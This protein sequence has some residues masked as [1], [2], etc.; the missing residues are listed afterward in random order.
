MIKTCPV[1]G[2]LFDC[3]YTDMWAYNIDKKVFFCSW[4]CIQQHRQ[5]KENDKMGKITLEQ[6]KKAV[7]I[8]AKGGDPVTFLQKCGSEKPSVSWAN[9][10]R[11]LETSKPELYDMLTAQK[12]PKVDKGMPKQE[13]QLEAGTNYEVSVKEEPKITKP[14]N[15]GGFQMTACKSEKTGIHYEYSAK[16][17][18]FYVKVADDDLD[19]TVDDWRKLL[20][21]VRDAARA[22]GVEL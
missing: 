11:A 3:L 17:N 1:C 4:K 15:Y 19:L 20:S 8:A 2:K 13:L 14:I 21:E 16:T 22:L 9:I 12:R 10:V 6:K 7:D 18:Y 5:E